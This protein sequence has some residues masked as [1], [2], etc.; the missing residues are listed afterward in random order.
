MH[1]LH[2]DGMYA[3]KRPL[4]LC[5]NSVVY[6]V[7]RGMISLKPSWIRTLEVKRKEVANNPAH[8]IR[9]CKFWRVGFFAKMSK[10][11]LYRYFIRHY[12]RLEHYT[13]NNAFTLKPT[14]SGGTW[15]RG[16]RDMISFYTVL[17]FTW[18]H[19][20]GFLVNRYL[21]LTFKTVYLSA[22]WYVC[23]RVCLSVCLS[24]LSFC[25]SVC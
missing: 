22:C 25:L 2:H 1:P 9:I 16:E 3:R 14:S 21:G 5:V 8:V 24:F 13:E 12:T 6:T 7:Y 17:F 11:V 20:F 19:V 15:L 23:V 18:G 10:I 4:P